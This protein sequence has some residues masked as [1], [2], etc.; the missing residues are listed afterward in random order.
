MTHRPVTR[1]ATLSL[2]HSNLSSTTLSSATLS[3]TRP[4]T[5]PHHHSSPPTH[6]PTPTTTDTCHLFEEA[7]GSAVR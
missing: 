1:P 3:S 6:T 2:L 5:D 4:I 7:V